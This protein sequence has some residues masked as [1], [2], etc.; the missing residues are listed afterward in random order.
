[1]SR[2]PRVTG[3]DVLT[4]LQRNGY[5]LIYIKGSHHYLEPPGGGPYITVPIHPGK[6]LKPRTLKSILAESGLTVEEFK[7]ML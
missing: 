6:I 3:K 1:M 5:T 4:A 7:D 2:L